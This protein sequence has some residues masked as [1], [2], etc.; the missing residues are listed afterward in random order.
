MQCT[1]KV[2]KDKM[3]TKPNDSKNISLLPLIILIS[4]S[5]MFFSKFGPTLLRSR[6]PWATGRT[7]TIK[8]IIQKNTMFSFTISTVIQIRSRYGMITLP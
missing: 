5:F 2:Q 6:R 8:L 1:K 7:V 4:I 3:S